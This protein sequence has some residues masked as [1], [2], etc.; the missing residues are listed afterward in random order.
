MELSLED[1]NQRNDT[2]YFTNENE[3]I[4]YLKSP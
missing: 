4:I 3:I 1:Y 2:E